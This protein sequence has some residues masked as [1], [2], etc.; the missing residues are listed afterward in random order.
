MTVDAEIGTL[1]DRG[2]PKDCDSRLEV[3]L[4]TFLV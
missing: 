1:R 3:A 4:G 2:V